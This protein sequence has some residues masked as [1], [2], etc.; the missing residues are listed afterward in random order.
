[1]TY[2]SVEDYRVDAGLFRFVEA[3][4]GPESA[5]FWQVLV[6]VLRDFGP[7]NAGLLAVRDGFQANLDDWHRTH[8]V[9]DAAAYRAFLTQI[10]YLVAE[11]EP[12]AVTT[13]GVD[14]E[15]ARMAG[16][17]L[18]VPV[19]NAR[20]ALNAG[21]A[22]WGSLYDALYGTDAMGSVPSGGG[23][24]PIRGTQVT[25][26]AKAWLDAFVP[27]AG[28][29]HASVTAYAVEAG[30]LVAQTA[31][32][33]VGLVVPEQFA[34]WRQGGILL[35]HNGLHLELVIDRDSPVGA[36]DPAGV[37]DIVVEA[38]L[39]AIM[40]MEDSVAAVDAEDKIGVYRNWLGLMRGDLSERF[41]K[42]GHDFRRRLNGDRGYTAPAGGPLVLHGR[43]LM[44]ARN[45]GL[46][47]YTDMVRDA[48]G[49]PVPEGLVDLVVTAMFA[50]HDLSRTEGL[51]NSRTGSVYI[52]K[53]K[54][55]GPDEV[56]FVVRTFA[57]VEA[58]LG[59]PERC[60]KIGIMDEE[61]RTSVNLATCIAAARDR[62]FFINTGFLDRTGDEIH[63]VMEAGPVLRKGDMKRAAWIGAY[64]ASNVDI[65]LMCGLPGHAQIG[66]G[67]WAAPDAMHEMMAQKIGHVQSGASTAW[68][69]SPTAAVLHALH[70]HMADVAAVQSNL[71]TRA[72]ASVDAILTPP[73]LDRVL[74][75]DEIQ[76]ELD[77]N[78][79]GLLGYVVRWIDAGIGCS[80]VPDIHDVGLME[81]RATL[82]IS[83]QHV[84]NW[85]RHGVVNA[86][87]VEA[88]LRHM[89][90][91]VDQQNVGDPGYVAM[92]PGFD[93]L[94]FAAARELVFAG[95]EQANGYTEFV[96]HRYRRL[97]K[98]EVRSV[99]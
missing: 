17:Q 92:A 29:S 76:E 22:R 26:Q 74:T 57:A 2:V 43:S 50:R 98:G 3:E 73:M 79:Q 96:L 90:A 45:V 35:R 63:S 44:L 41:V 12:F 15:I 53:P 61:R 42:N 6:Q 88:R 39:S 71:K 14:D 87:L 83:S 56:A 52:V 78:L 4:T 19:S 64:E 80:K 97:A 38:A 84:A 47:M 55:H 89:A 33:A 54:L 1:M 27:L 77:N 24:D 37:A 93:G 99:G 68:V 91:V 95:R 59:L 65:G 11:P 94:A 70:Y 34:G 82:R 60:L 32:G 5:R 7:E 20:Y 69:P 16:P 30:Q 46:H 49:Q 10:G 72:R 67:M 13:D 31:A 85:L 81:D 28:A 75:P 40:D 62:V 25:A 18:V 8:R 51:R 66:K 86:D 58:L 48:E 36:A 21:N 9:H 23:Y